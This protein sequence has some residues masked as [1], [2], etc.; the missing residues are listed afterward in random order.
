M[1]S[2]RTVASIATALALTACG[3][4]TEATVMPSS[5]PP[6]A[7][8]PPA[9]PSAASA[10]SSDAA[11]A[12]TEAAAQ[13]ADR[14]T[15]HVVIDYAMT[16][17]SRTIEY[18]MSG[19]MNASGS[20]SRLT[21]VLTPEGAGAPEDVHIESRSVGG[22]IYYRYRGG[23]MPEDWFRSDDPMQQGSA[24]DVA[25]QLRSM[26]AL[27]DLE[28]VGT[29]KIGAITTTHYRATMDASR[30]SSF[31]GSMGGGQVAATEESAKA[32]V[33]TWID[34]RKRPVKQTLTFTFTANGTTVTAKTTMRFSNWGERCTVTAPARW[35]PI[36]ELTSGR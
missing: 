10:G 17:G 16:G 19:C 12:I 24:G 13:V 23:G 18:T 32:P 9:S 34:N 25:D 27:A 20:R 5:A 1:A 21:G 26:A 35:R 4:A 6:S 29:E 30:I 31:L 2:L 33:E 14:K 36:S 15:T 11:Q 8:A 7:A 22:S 28:K 3:G